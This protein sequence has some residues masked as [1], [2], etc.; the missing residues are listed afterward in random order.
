MAI[1]VRHYGAEDNPVNMAQRIIVENYCK[2]I[3]EIIAELGIWKYGVDATTESGRNF[4]VNT[5]EQVTSINSKYFYMS[6][7]VNKKS[8]RIKKENW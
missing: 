2:K 5:S 4:V 7:I 3:G 8:I 1:I 6:E